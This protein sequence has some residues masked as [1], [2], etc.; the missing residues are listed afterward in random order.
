MPASTLDVFV[1]AKTMP[2]LLMEWLWHS[3]NKRH[4]LKINYV[5]IQYLKFKFV[6]AM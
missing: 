6:L 4:V 5:F 2:P 3:T 1:T